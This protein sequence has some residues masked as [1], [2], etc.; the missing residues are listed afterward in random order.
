MLF[1]PPPAYQLSLPSC[2]RISGGGAEQGR[3][4]PAPAHRRQIRV[5]A[6]GCL[7]P[8]HPAPVHE[9]EAGKHTSGGRSSTV[10]YLSNALGTGF[11]TFA[12]SY[13]SLFARMGYKKELYEHLIE[14]RTKKFL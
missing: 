11:E 9:R 10:Q 7:Q 8:G 2:R 1:G 12:V 3:H 6:A 13:F 5:R 4:K 14:Q